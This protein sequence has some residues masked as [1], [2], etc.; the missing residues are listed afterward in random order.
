M[1]ITLEQAK[2]ILEENGQQHL[3]NEYEKLGVNQKQKLLNQIANIDFS[4]MKELY[5]DTKKTIEYKECKIEPLSYIDKSKLGEDEY[6]QYEN[7]GIEAIK[8]GK[9]AAVTMAGGQGTRLG[10]NRTKRNI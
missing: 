10:H 9:L 1:E 4:L 8:K 3:L 2:K 7:K 6:K 5:E